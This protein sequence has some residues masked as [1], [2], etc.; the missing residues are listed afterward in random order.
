MTYLQSIQ[1]FILLN[2]QNK[3]YKA[4]TIH[5]PNNDVMLGQRRRLLSNITPLLG[6][7]LV[8]AG[9]RHH[10]EIIFILASAEH[11]RPGNLYY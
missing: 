4:N 6:E 9:Y 8:L 10:L 2:Q 5:S 1:Q 11:I 7:F 3:Y